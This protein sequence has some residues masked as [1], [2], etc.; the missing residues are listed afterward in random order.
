MP[1]Q[2]VYPAQD[3]RRQDLPGFIRAVNVAMARLSQL[4]RSVVRGPDAAGGTTNKV[5]KWTAHH[6]LDDSGI[7]DTGTLLGFYGTAGT[8]RPSA[9]TQTYSTA[10]RTHAG[11]TADNEG[12][13][14]T[15]IDNLQPGSVYATV[16]DLN[17][18]RV[19]YENLR[20]HHESTAQVLNTVVDD[21]QAN[22]LE[23]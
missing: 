16:A 4:F 12:S 8:A 6:T 20:A 10:S 5:A 18:L 17:A 11:Y 22:G 21:L 14:Y 2:W 23:Q 7:T 9:I 15:G 3:D 19:A 13:A 1:E